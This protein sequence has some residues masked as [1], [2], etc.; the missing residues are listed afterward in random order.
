MAKQFPLDYNKDDINFIFN[1]CTMSAYVN[2]NSEYKKK[3]SETRIVLSDASLVNAFASGAN[4]SFKIQIN[5][6]LCDIC[7]FI[8]LALAKY[9]VDRNEL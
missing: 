1:M 3:A 7:A 5:A 8:G 2:N 9:R 6:G 4:S